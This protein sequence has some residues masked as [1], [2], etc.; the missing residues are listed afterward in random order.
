[1]EQVI[2]TSNTC[3]DV[4]YSIKDI[5]VGKYTV[6]DGEPRYSNGRNYYILT[7]KFNETNEIYKIYSDYILTNHINTLKSYKKFIFEKVLDFTNK[8]GSH[9]EIA[10]SRKIVFN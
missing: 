1:M 10:G 3:S 7:V 2:D 8:Y 9:I 6:L 5:P 4:I